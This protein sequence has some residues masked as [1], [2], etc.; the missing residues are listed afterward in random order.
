MNSPFSTLTLGVWLPAIAILISY[1]HIEYALRITALIL[2]I[3]ASLVA[4]YSKL[5]K[6][7][8]DKE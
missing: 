2:G 4:L 1:Q 3:I 7:G 6:G 8:K 5:A